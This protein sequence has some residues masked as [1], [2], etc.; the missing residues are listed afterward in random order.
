M[1]EMVISQ[2]ACTKELNIGDTHITPHHSDHQI[3]HVTNKA[4]TIEGHPGQ[5]TGFTALLHVNTSIMS[6]ITT[7]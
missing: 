6:Y 7:T 5:I 4:F 2:T 1:V 3:Q